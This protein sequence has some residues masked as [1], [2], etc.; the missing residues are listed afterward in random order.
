MY[1]LTSFYVLLPDPWSRS[2]PGADHE[3]LTRDFAKGVTLRSVILEGGKMSP[4]TIIS[5]TT[6]MEELTLVKCSVLDDLSSP[7]ESSV[8]EVLY[9][10]C[11]T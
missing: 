5:T 8:K 9:K 1:L 3:I 2:P 11:F 4:G 7:S 10:I 6:L